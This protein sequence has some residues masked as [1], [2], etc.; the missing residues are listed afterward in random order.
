MDVSVVSTQAKSRQA[1]TPDNFVLG[2][3]NTTSRSNQD[4]EPYG[5]HEFTIVQR[6]S[7]YALIKSLLSDRIG[8]AVM[9]VKIAQMISDQ[10]ES[11]EQLV[12]IKPLTRITVHLTMN[13]TF[14]ARL[15]GVDVCKTIER[16]HRDGRF[17]DILEKHTGHRSLTH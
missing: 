11:E 12:A 17:S 14:A 4:W 2:W 5:L 3:L 13:Q 15:E 10:L 1:F 16:L 8:G 6:L 7:N 9:N